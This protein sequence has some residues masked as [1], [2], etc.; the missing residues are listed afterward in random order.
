MRVEV[1]VEKGE[2]GN[3]GNGLYFTRFI[4]D[5][6]RSQP[7][8]VAGID[9]GRFAAQQLEAAVEVRAA[10][11][12][13]GSASSDSGAGLIP[14]VADDRHRARLPSSRARATAMNPATAA[15]ERS[16]AV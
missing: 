14:G 1:A 15:R 8:P 11:P 5:A 3:S 13:T 4:V 7:E 2:V 6:A 10:W 16:S 9:R 12:I